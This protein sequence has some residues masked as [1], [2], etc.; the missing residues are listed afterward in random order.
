MR[1]LLSYS[2]VL[3]TALVLAACSRSDTGTPNPATNATSEK[4]RINLG[5]GRVSFVPP[6]NL[7]QLT[8]EQI[9][10]S[11]FGGEKPADYVFSN[12]PQTVTIGVVLNFI[13]LA[14]DQLEDYI[15]ANRRLLSMTVQD[16]QFLAHELVTINGRGWVHFEIVSEVPEVNLHNHQYTTSFY[17]GA[18]VF[19]FNSTVREYEQYK[20]EF[21]KSAQS[22]VVRD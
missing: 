14:P 18:L 8:K 6:P 1:N 4:G 2:C 11:K 3:L 17:G 13:E 15:D 7:K 9:A 5:D 16:V 10:A 22:I 20:N 19:G 21:L 12:D